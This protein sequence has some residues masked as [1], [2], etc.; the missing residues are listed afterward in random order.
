MNPDI[1]TKIDQLKYATWAKLG[2]EPNTLYLNMGDYRELCI[3]TQGFWL[4]K[5]QR[6]TQIMLMQIVKRQGSMECAYVN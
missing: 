3:S 6:L 5:G 4:P 2:Q 1:L